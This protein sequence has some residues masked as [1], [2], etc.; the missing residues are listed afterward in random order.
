M[1]FRYAAANLT[2]K[3]AL[4]KDQELFLGLF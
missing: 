1:K 3:E 4:G 2:I